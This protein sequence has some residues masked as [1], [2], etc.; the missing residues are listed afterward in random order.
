[1]EII[2]QTMFMD[3]NGTPV[4]SPQYD[5]AR[6]E[7]FTAGE[8]FGGIVVRYSPGFSLFEVTYDNGEAV[9]SP[10]LF[11]E[12]QR[13]WLFGNVTTAGMPPVRL[14]A[15]APNKVTTGS[16]E[17]K[18]WPAGLGTIP[19]EVS[20]LSSGTS[21][22]YQELDAPDNPFTSYDPNRPR[23]TDSD[24]VP[25]AYDS[26]PLDPN[27]RGDYVDSD[28]DSIPNHL[29]PRPYQADDL[30]GMQDTDGDGV[31]DIY[32]PDPNDNEIPD[33]QNKDEFEDETDDT[34][35]DYAAE[36]WAEIP[37]TRRTVMHR[38][39]LD[40]ND[41]SSYVDVERVVYLECRDE[42]GRTFKLRMLNG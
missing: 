32:D 12:M 18:I 23:D 36:N 5:A 1:V 4:P 31:P 42:Q 7:F 21:S 11:A 14:V 34:N 6:A 20:G 22:A 9:A 16:F 37:G 40:L 10:Q 30:T 41:P 8:A 35:K 29:D 24:G 27:V 19:P 33:E 2:Q 25:D 13:A 17:R 39:S 28:G 38:I 15:L 26:D 3:K